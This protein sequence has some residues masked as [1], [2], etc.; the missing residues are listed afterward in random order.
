VFPSYWESF[1]ITGLEAMSCGKAIVATKLGFSEYLEDGH[2]GLIIEPGDSAKL[3]D[4]IKC[5]MENSHVRTK[6]EHNAREKALQY[7]WSKIVQQYEQLY[8]S[9]L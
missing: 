3:I 8:E 2:D 9:V 7:D 5:L 6:L 1:G 4:A